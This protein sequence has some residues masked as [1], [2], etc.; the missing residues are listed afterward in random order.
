M[1]EANELTIHIMAAVAQAERK[2]IS[3]R[4]KDALAATEARRRRVGGFRGN[5]DDLRKV[6]HASAAA[7][8]RAAADRT[9]KV[10]KQ[11]DAVRVAA[12]VRCVRLPRLCLWVPSRRRAALVAG[13]DSAG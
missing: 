9:A 5:L 11:I 8:G 3:R 1:P 7:R 2:G 6:P 12:R 4:T 13:A 10:A